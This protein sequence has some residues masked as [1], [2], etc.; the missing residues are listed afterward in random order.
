MDYEEALLQVIDVIKAHN[1]Y[2]MNTPNYEQTV[3]TIR[4]IVTPKGEWIEECDEKAEPLKR[5]EFYCT[6]CGNWN[7]YGK[8]K[9]CMKCG[10]RMDGEENG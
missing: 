10:A 8:P 2:H 3:K 7:T 9:F 1:R 4:D 5:R 6:V